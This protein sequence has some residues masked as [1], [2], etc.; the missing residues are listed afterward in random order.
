MELLWEYRWLKLYD[1]CILQFWKFDSSLYY[2]CFFQSQTYRKAN[3][4]NCFQKYANT[5]SNIIHTQAE[6]SL[7]QRFVFPW[8]QGRHLS[9]FWSRAILAVRKQNNWIQPN[10]RFISWAHSYFNN[11]LEEISPGGE[12][13]F[14]HD[15]LL[16]LKSLNPGSINSVEVMHWPLEP[17]SFILCRFLQ[18]WAK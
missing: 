7:M 8:Y 4:G 6:W 3:L 18:C 5:I 13:A 17:I 10:Y 1:V 15:W 14:L 11:N 12:W 9:H 16:A 2:F